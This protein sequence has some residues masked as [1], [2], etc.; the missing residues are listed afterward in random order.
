MSAA[1]Y[2]CIHSGSC[3]CKVFLDHI[4]LKQRKIRKFNQTGEKKRAYFF[5]SKWEHHVRVNQLFHLPTNKGFFNCLTYSRVH[6]K[7]TNVT[8]RKDKYITSPWKFIFYGMHVHMSQ[9]VINIAQPNE[10]LKCTLIWFRQK[11]IES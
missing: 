8:E 5:A 2:T 3:W 9:T 11:K 6:C 10:L 4:V 7:E 1:T